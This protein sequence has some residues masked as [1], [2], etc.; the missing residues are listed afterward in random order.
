MIGFIDLMY[1]VE[2]YLLCL[3]TKAM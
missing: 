2:S 3:E 1:E